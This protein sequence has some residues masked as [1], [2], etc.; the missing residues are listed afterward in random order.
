[1]EDGTCAQVALQVM[2]EYVL[3]VSDDPSDQVDSVMLQH[4]K[5]ETAHRAADEGVD[6]EVGDLLNAADGVLLG[7][8]R[9]VHLHV[10]PSVLAGHHD[11]V[12][13]V[14]PVRNTILHS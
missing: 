7:K 14:Q 4:A 10:P 2:M 9:L 13:A 5:N 6:S 8:R 11:R 1:V 12:G 3:R